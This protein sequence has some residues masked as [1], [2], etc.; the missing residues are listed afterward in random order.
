MSEGGKDLKKQSHSE[1]RK[2]TRYF[3]LSPPQPHMDDAQHSSNLNHFNSLL[4]HHHH[5][6]PSE[7]RQFQAASKDEAES[8]LDMLG[9]FVFGDA[10]EAAV[11]STNGIHPSVVSGEGLNQAEERVEDGLACETPV[12]RRRTASFRE[13]V[14]D[15]IR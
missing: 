13:D 4:L 10:V 1:K 2:R 6:S 15:L 3:V 12:T 8:W 5:Q 14:L 9:A 7:P 11:A